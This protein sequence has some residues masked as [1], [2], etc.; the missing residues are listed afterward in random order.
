MGLDKTNSTTPFLPFKAPPLTFYVHKHANNLRPLVPPK[1]PPG[2]LQT[3]A[4]CP[5]N[6]RL[7][8]H[9]LPPVTS[10]PPPGAPQTVTGHLAGYHNR[11]G[12]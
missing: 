12:F 9:K 3:A 1:V 4:R 7:V 5:A 11:A 8:P 10:K 6:R 2:A